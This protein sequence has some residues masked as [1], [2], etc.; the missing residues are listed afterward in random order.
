MSVFDLLTVTFSESIHQPIIAFILHIELTTHCKVIKLE[1]LNNP[2][3]EFRRVC[4]QP[5]VLEG[6]RFL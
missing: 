4:F 2:R 1:Y 5:A 3:K 6:T